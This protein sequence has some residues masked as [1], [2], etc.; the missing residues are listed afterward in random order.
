MAEIKFI[1]KGKRYKFNYDILKQKTIK[2]N[3]I[4]KQQKNKFR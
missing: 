4:K 3:Q 2:I 1:R